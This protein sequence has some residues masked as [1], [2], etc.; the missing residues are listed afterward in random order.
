MTMTRL[1]ECR[2]GGPYEGEWRPLIP[3]QALV[4]HDADGAYLG[5][6]R[7]AAYVNDDDPPWSVTEPHWFWSWFS[8]EF[9]RECSELPA[10]GGAG[11]D[12]G[13]ALP[14]TTA[15]PAACRSGTPRIRSRAMTTRPG[16]LFAFEGIDGAGKT[17]QA[18][19]LGALLRQLGHEF[20]IAK[21]PTHGPWGERIRASFQT[22][23]LPP[24]DE[25]KCFVEDRREH[26]RDVIA[27]M[28]AKG[29]HV[30]LDR[31]FVSSAAYQGA[32]GLIAEEIL[33]HNEE[34]APIPARVFILRVSPKT[35][36]ARIAAR[37]QGSNLFE[38]EE[39]L[40]AT[41]KEFDGL[42]RDYFDVIDGER[43]AQ[44][45]AA[46]VWRAVEAALFIRQGG[47][48]AIKDAAAKI[49]HDP[50][51]STYEKVERVRKL[52]SSQ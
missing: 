42:R 16:L 50:R 44:D 22:G 31:Y 6:Y 40:V 32:R 52:L 35:A 9:E 7:Q 11:G 23:R 21:E 26:V 8:A 33:R 3:H 1:L 37:G 15:A 28:L 20:I 5:S 43:P 2:N 38:R 41:A 36:L 49:A 27:P 34:F 39:S 51:L 30:I 10:A 47:A 45:V 46:D 12:E 4:V 19:T 17:T 13:V 29:V 25:L 48:A 14:N 18:Q 24:A